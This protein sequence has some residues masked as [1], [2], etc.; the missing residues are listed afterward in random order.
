M[1]K[2]QASNLCTVGVTDRRQSL[3]VARLD[4]S[5][6]LH[7]NSHDIGVP[8]AYGQI[9]WRR[10]AVMVAGVCQRWIAREHR[11][12]EIN[13]AGTRGIAKLFRLRRVGAEAYRFD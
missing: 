1:I 12:N 11:A 10:A 3:S 8:A 6:T 13:V 2:E 9:Q 5:A 4:V 7:K